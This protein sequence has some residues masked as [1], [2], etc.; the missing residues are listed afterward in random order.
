[1]YGAVQD[2]RRSLKVGDGLA[3]PVCGQN[4]GVEEG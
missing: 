3:L 2:S 1:M 4:M